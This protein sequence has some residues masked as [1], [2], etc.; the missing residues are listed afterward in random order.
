[1]FVGQYRY[2]DA[3][4]GYEVQDRHRLSSLLYLNGKYN[5]PHLAFNEPIYIDKYQPDDWTGALDENNTDNGLP[6][7]IPLL[8]VPKYKDRRKLYFRLKSDTDIFAGYVAY[9]NSTV[10]VTST[11]ILNS[12]TQ[13]MDDLK[14]EVDLSKMLDGVNIVYSKFGGHGLYSKLGMFCA[15]GILKTL[16]GDVLKITL[17]FSQT[18]AYTPSDKTSDCLGISVNFVFDFDTSRANFQPWKKSETWAQSQSNAIEPI[19][20]TFSDAS[21]MTD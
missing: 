5:Y 9:I 14:I 20:R 15:T 19:F 18:H 1:M 8:T 3:V 21:S 7:F 6:E 2:L 11:Y 17:T 13:F 10:C 12:S 16:V 4:S